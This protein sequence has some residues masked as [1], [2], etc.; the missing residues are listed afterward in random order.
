M[1]IGAETPCCAYRKRYRRKAGQVHRL[2]WLAAIRKLRP[3]SVWS[4]INLRVFGI[5][6]WTLANTSHSLIVNL[7]LSEL[8][9]NISSNRWV[10]GGCWA[11]I[12]RLLRGYSGV[13]RCLYRRVQIKSVSLGKYKISD[14]VL[15]YYREASRTRL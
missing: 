4:L 12:L 10:L 8:N 6:T 2:S 3:K 1:L 14:T 9:P 13:V 5:T 7:Y 11:V 15:R